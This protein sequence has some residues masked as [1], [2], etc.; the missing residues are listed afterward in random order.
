MKKV[1]YYEEGGKRMKRFRNRMFAGAMSFVMALGM[2]GALAYGVMTDTTITAEAA[3]QANVY[4]VDD[5]YYTVTEKNEVTLL[6]YYGSNSSVVF[7]NTIEG[8]KVTRIV[9]DVFG[10]GAGAIKS[11]TIP[12]NIQ[13]IEE[14]AFRYCTQLEQ[15]NCTSNSNF[16][17]SSGML[18][19]T[20]EVKKGFYVDPKGTISKYDEAGEQ[21][22]MPEGYDRMETPDIT[23][24][25]MLLCCTK[26]NQ[27]ISIPDGVDAIGAYAFYNANGYR[28]KLN[29]VTLPTSIKYIGDYAFYGCGSLAYMSSTQTAEGENSFNIPYETVYIGDF[30]FMR[31]ASIRSLNLPANLWGVGAC[32]F[33]NCGNLK[34][35]YVPDNVYW[36]GT[37]SFGYQYFDYAESMADIDESSLQKVKDFLLMSKVKVI[38]ENG[39]YSVAAQY[40]DDQNMNYVDEE[41]YQNSDLDDDGNHTGNHTYVGAE[42]EIISYDTVRT[43]DPNNDL[44]HEY[45]YTAMVAPTCTTPGG[46]AGICYCGHSFFYEFP[47]YNHAYLPTVVPPT[48]TEEGYTAYICARCGDELI[49]ELHPKTDITEPTG[50]K[51]VDYV[52]SPT[53]REGGYTEHICEWCGDSY[54]DNETEKLVC[55]DHDFTYEETTPATCTSEGEKKGTCSKC[56]YECTEKIPKADHSYTWED[57]TPATCTEDGVRTYTCS[58]C[59]DNY[60]ETLNKLGHQY[61]GK[62]TTEATCKATGVKTFTCKRCQRSYTETIAKKKHQ[63]V[64][65][66]VEPTATEGGYTEHVCSVCGYSYKDNFTETLQTNGWSKDSAGKWYYFEDGEVS[67]GWKKIQK[68]WYYFSP[69][70][71]TLGQMQTGWQQIGKKWY[72]FNAS[73]AML[74]G[75]QTLGKK[76]YFFKADGSMA[77]NE[78]C[79]GYWLNKDGTWTYKP[80]ASWKKDKKG[81][82][83]IDTKGWYAKS[84]TLTIDGKKY[85]FDAKG[86]MK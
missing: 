50:H 56:G 36:L 42:G 76:T 20:K 46:A 74:T 19:Y 70:S 83:F 67:T 65:K 22:D 45:A 25:K 3:D 63:Y 11:I 6:Y 14:G 44:D 79:K 26:D 24:K 62:V 81:W 35:V 78:Y 51:Y 54:I 2:G 41:T 48:C 43:H 66:V 7:P 21:V 5:F 73:G 49:D 9:K 58:G 69:K 12:S 27:Q 33:L 52:T 55:T 23:V 15:I 77:A 30:A 32:A 18:Y 72:Y 1:L 59:G 40:A 34:Q 8:K 61:V 16:K 84:C 10:E 82:Y 57:T 60:T 85:K 17:F 38:D 64:D 47:A 53:Y 29:S 39:D 71:A 37:W 86:Y 68:K 31:C 4:R 28:E 80:K 13:V 75:W